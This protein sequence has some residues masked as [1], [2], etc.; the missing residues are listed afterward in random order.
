M[1]LIEELIPYP[2][3]RPRSPRNGNGQSFRDQTRC[4]HR[5]IPPRGARSLSLP[6]ACCWLS[7]YALRRAGGRFAASTTC[8]L[9]LGGVIFVHL[10]SVDDAVAARLVD[11]FGED[12]RRCVEFLEAAYVLLCVGF[13]SVPRWGQTV[14]FCLREAMTAVLKAARLGDAG[15]W[16]E[17]SRDVVT[18]GGEYRR[19][20]HSPDSERDRLLGVLL[21][22]IDDLGRFHREEE[23]RRRRL[24]DVM[25]NLTG[26]APISARVSPVDAYQ[27]LCVRLNDI[28]HSPDSGVDAEGLWVECLA[29]LR[30]LF[31]P[32]DRRFPELEQLARVESPNGGDRNRVVGLVAS[33]QHLRQFLEGVASPAWLA[34]LSETGHLDPPDSPAGWWIDTAVERLALSHPQEVVVWLEDTY[35]QHGQDPT[36]AAHIARAAAMA[37]EPAVELMLT[38]VSVHQ[39]H[40]T[41]LHW[42]IRSVRRLPASDQRVEDFADVILNPGSWSQAGAPWGLLQRLSEGATEENVER[43]IR[44]LCYKIRSVSPDDFGLWSLQHGASGSI[45]DSDSAR[46]YERV[47]ALLACLIETVTKSLE[48]VPLSNLMALV[49]LMPDGLSERTRVWILARVPSVNPQILIDEVTRAISSRC[50]TGDDLAL[51]DRALRDCEPSRF[52]GPW[53]AALGEAPTITEV[54]DAIREHD[55]PSDWFRSAEWA[56]LLPPHSAGG[57]VSPTELLVPDKQVRERLE[58]KSP[59]VT[60]VRARS[61]PKN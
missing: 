61:A 22:R 9:T 42:G 16:K 20:K 24:T 10:E 15:R 48:W 3:H 29:T 12:G 45:A 59:M 60:E 27:E 53:N 28:V 30:L 58:R 7:V 41:I 46:E 14:A 1:G 31:L 6:H 34:L 47:P 11:E 19:V 2:A 36:R 21:A 23:L 32:P 26:A 50:P 33:P 51:V 57:W 8:P 17:I 13:R 35:S 5:E 37:G 49:G 54:G 52:T 18:A 43:R 25:V 40:R 4:G 39:Q 44:L 55:I 56:S 38:I